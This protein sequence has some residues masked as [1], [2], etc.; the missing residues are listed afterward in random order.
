[1]IL[2]TPFLL[3]H[4]GTEPYGIWIL[5]QNLATYFN[6]FNLGFLSNMVAQYATKTT[7]SE[8]AKN[9]LFSTVFFSL[10]MFCF[11]SIPAF[12]YI[13]E[14]FEIIFK[15]T[16]SNVMLGK[17]VFSV[18]YLSF[19]SIFL[20]S[21]FDMI[22]YYIL[23]NIVTKNIIDI[24]RL[25]VL[26]LGY[27]A[28]IFLG[29]GV[30]EIALFYLSIQLLIM[31][32][33][34]VFAKKG[35]NLH[36]STINFDYQ[37]FKSF[38]KPSFNFLLL[39]LANMIIF[40]GDNII[41]SALIGVEQLVIFSLSFKLS[42]TAIRLINKLV[43]VKSPMMITYIK[44]KDYFNLKAEFN[45]LVY[46]SL[47]LS[48]IAMIFIILCGKLA[49]IYWLGNKY[50]FDNYVIGIFAVFI[51][52]NSLYYVCWIFLNLTGQHSRLSYVVL[53]E[54][55]LN[56]ILSYFLGKQFGLIGI[57]SGTLIASICTSGWFAYYECKRYFRNHI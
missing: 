13:Y 24:C 17:K 40:A 1:M 23:G 37:L 57:A 30:F 33:L 48:F 8:E 10:V 14:H 22:L 28:I 51:M 50:N 11:L 21:T 46:W 29:G 35:C 47:G 53:L 5:C 15:I 9:K 4:L 36:I 12:W 45:K 42:D 16:S 18:V 34:Y 27:I 20:A 39:N 6:L 41:I 38:F 43:D 25:L 56:I 2:V 7:D 54:I 3:E 44:T 52:T 26:N 31:I 19:I 55:V 49:L 32:T